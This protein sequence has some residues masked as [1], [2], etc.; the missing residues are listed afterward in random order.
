MQNKSDKAKLSRVIA[1][2]NIFNALFM[3]V[4]S[5]LAILLLNA[6][7]TIAEFLLLASLMNIVVALILY[8]HDPTFFDFK[9]YFI[10]KI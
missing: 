7:M 4:A 9:R 10:N 5:V 6:G 8:W 3:V 2:N 1:G